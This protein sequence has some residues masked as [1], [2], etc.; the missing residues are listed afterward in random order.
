MYVDNEPFKLY[1]MK[2][3]WIKNL[4]MDSKD[5]FNND[6]CLMVVKGRLSLKKFET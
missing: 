6:S 4:K 3:K 2:S 5:C 1:R